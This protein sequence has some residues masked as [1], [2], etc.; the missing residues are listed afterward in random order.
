MH[1]AKQIP[2]TNKAT[3]EELVAAGLETGLEDEEC[4][5]GHDE[6]IGVT[7]LQSKRVRT[8]SEVQKC[9]PLHIYGFTEYICVCIYIYIYI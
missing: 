3:A 7:Y 8:Q 5:P 1:T 9:I 2:C 6:Y 4:G